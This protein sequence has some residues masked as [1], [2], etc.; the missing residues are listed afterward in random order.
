[1]IYLISGKVLLKLKDF[2]VVDA[3]GVGFKI[4]TTEKV[5]KK[6]NLDEKNTFY[7][8]FHFRESNIELYGFL[9]QKELEFFELLNSVSGVG[10]KSALSILEKNDI[11]TLSLAI[12]NNK[13]EFL[14]RA[15]GIG[16]KTAER[17]VLELKNKI[18]LIS[19]DKNIDLDSNLDVLE[20]LISLGYNKQEA[21]QAIAG[22]DDSLKSFEEKFKTALK[23]LNKK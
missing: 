20:A 10:P 15:S 19:E 8:Y 4:F 12:K 16:Q 21:K 18:E 3:G 17:I 14:T 22:L 7:I 1:M 2:L 13:I 11:K 23:L 6:I 9:D 5:L